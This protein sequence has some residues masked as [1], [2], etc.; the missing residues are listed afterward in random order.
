M[1][2]D[3]LIRA[4]LG[5]IIG[6]AICITLYAIGLFDEIVLDNKGFMILQFIGSALL[7]FVAM[8]G[9]IVYDVEKWGLTKVTVIHFSMTIIVFVADYLILKWFPLNILPIVLAVFIVAYF[10]IWLIN[11]VIYNRSIKDINSDL[12]AL[13]KREEG[14]A[15]E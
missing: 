7:G 12:D 8:G 14:D 3:F 4:L 13:R 5:T 9:T 15:D 10:I 2:K 1:K 6:L 11:F